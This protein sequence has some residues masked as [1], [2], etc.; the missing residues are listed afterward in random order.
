MRILAAFLWLS[1]LGS[2]Q[3]LS[4]FTTPLPVRKGDAIVVGFLGGFESWNDPH[5]SVWRV[6]QALRQSGI[7]ADTV[8]NRR[9]N[10]AKKMILRALDWNHDGKLDAEER[11]GARIVLYGQSLGGDAAIHVAKALN[12]MNIP[13]LLT[14]QVDS[15]GLH[16]AVI[17]PN[18]AAAINFY[19]H[20]PLTFQGR[21]EIRAADPERTRILGNFQL[22]YENKIIDESSA[23]WVR[24]TFGGAHAKMEL[25]PEVWGRVEEL[26]L[27]AARE[28]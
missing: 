15:V 5:R 13:V 28:P 9:R 27:E 11:A 8:E 16:D 2:A 10:V 24:R 3:R 25:D 17:P 7:Y 14:V 19:Q 26:I 6:A 12:E 21:R 22:N 4:D 20:E 18:V 1:S 23:T